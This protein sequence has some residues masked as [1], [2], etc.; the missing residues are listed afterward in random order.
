MYTGPYMYKFALN[1]II[2]VWQRETKQKQQGQGGWKNKST[3]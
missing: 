3:F 2:M 1:W